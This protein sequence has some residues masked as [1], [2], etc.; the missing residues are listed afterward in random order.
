VVGGQMKIGPY[1]ILQ[2]TDP[3][4]VRHFWQGNSVC[5]TMWIMDPKVLA[6]DSTVVHTTVLIAE[7]LPCRTLDSSE[8]RRISG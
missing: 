2:I 4:D 3:D 1:L 7:Q 5:S 8:L 6:A